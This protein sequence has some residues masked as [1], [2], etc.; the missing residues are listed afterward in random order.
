MQYDSPHSYSRFS[1]AIHW[2]SALFICALFGA[3]FWMVELSYYDAGYQLI[4]HYHKSIGVMLAGL[5]IIRVVWRICNTRPLALTS[6]STR[7]KTLSYIV[8]LLLYLLTF[9]VVIAGYLISTEDGRGIDVFNWFTIPS[10]G[11]LFDNQ[12]DIAGN[13]HRWMAYT[14][15][16]LGG[17]HGIAALKHHFYDKDETLKRML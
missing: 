17:L 10:L 15:I 16:T 4:P 12:A 11:K 8:Q 14:L 5:M 13:L 7:E 2:L 3:G 6:H 1:K 9:S